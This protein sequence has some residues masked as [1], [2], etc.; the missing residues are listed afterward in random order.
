[1]PVALLPNVKP[2]EPRNPADPYWK[3]ALTVLKNAVTDPALDVMGTSPIAVGTAIAKA[4]RAIG[5]MM[6]MQDEMMRALR[7]ARTVADDVVGVVD[8]ASQLGPRINASG[9]SAASM[10]SLG[11]RSWERAT[12]RQPV[13]IDRAGREVPFIGE[14][15]DVRPNPGERLG[16][17]YG[18]GRFEEIARGK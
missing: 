7:G 1:M 8:E 18:N 10:E 6:S 11:R 9:E 17:R 12:G 4:P 3:Q 5:G 14:I 13:R 15:G 2:P 16:Y